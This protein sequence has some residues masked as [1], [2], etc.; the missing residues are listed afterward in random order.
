MK[1]SGFVL[2]ALLSLA[3]IPAGFA[4]AADEEQQARLAEIKQRIDTLR[5][6]W[7]PGGAVAHLWRT[8]HTGRM[9][10]RAVRV[11][12]FIS[13]TGTGSRHRC[14]GGGQPRRQRGWQRGH[15]GASEHWPNGSR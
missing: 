7:R 2:A 10:G 4:Q 14:R 1:F 8:R 9:T 11:V 3:L 13:G 12:H 5:S 15:I 6:A